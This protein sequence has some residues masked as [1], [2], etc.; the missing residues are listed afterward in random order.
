LSAGE[1]KINGDGD[2]TQD[3]NDVLRG[4]DI[5]PGTSPANGTNHTSE[6]SPKSEIPQFD[7]ANDIMAEQR[8]ITAVRR[9]GPDKR[10]EAIKQETPAIIKP[11]P[12]AAKP[13]QQSGGDVEND[14][15]IVDIVR[16]DIERLCKGLD[17]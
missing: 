1:K 10:T 8:K 11:A 15:I 7:L 4:S 13:V 16:R 12:P 3:S 5:I 9:K 2:I 17:G 6:D 14:K